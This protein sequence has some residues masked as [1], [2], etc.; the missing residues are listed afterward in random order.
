MAKSTRIVPI[1]AA[2][3]GAAFI[4]SATAAATPAEGDVQRTDL[5]T[6]TTNTPISIVTNGEDTAF[7]VQRLI[8]KPGGSS[9]WHTHPGP[10]QSVI[11]KGTVFVQTATDCVP[12]AFTAGQTVFLPAG[13]AHLVK[14][15]GP[16]DAEVVVTYT[17][18]ADLAV[19]DDAPAACP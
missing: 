6:G 5:A 13:L 3:I 12:T 16:E 8:V 18:P 1:A 2:A 15:Q 19:R 7:Y 9:G 10:E 11:T 14:N 4:W 17:L